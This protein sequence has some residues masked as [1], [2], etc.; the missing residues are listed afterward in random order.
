MKILSKNVI[1]TI[2][3]TFMFIVTVS[4]DFVLA[5]ANSD[6]KVAK[7]KIEVKNLEKK[8][9]NTNSNEE[10]K[11][12]I[13]NSEK[14]VVI[15]FVGEKTDELEKVFNKV[16]TITSKEQIDEYIDKN[17]SIDNISI[18]NKYNEDEDVFKKTTKIELRNGMKLEVIEV[19]EP[20][21]D[22]LFSNILIDSVY[23]ASGNWKFIHSK[24]TYPTKKFGKRMYTASHHFG[25][26]LFPD[27]YAKA[28]IGYT[29]S[30]SKKISGRYLESF[31]KKNGSSFSGI[32]FTCYDKIKRRWAANS[33]YVSGSVYYDVTYRLYGSDANR[34]IRVYNRVTVR[35]WNKNSASLEQY[36][37]A[38]S[39]N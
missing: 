4:S 29:L 34:E 3:V 20:E 1:I 24:G 18:D 33:S 35:K 36:S 25:G 7:N 32:D 14:E 38:Y 2:I 39:K 6:E 10:K 17:N 21:E 30:K 12:I 31:N 22:S 5:E 28:R 9:K 27:G 16:S 26:G 11:K 8:L 37:S 19:D 13:K 23:A 15:S